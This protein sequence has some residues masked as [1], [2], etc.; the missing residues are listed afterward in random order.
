MTATAR[1]L[2]D[3]VMAD[4]RKAWDKSNPTVAVVYTEQL[5]PE[6][7][8]IVRRVVEAEGYSGKERDVMMNKVSS[9]IVGKVEALADHMPADN[10][11]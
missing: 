1:E 6:D 2:A 10:G 4:R 3:R 5:N 7:E 11:D 8:A 9:L